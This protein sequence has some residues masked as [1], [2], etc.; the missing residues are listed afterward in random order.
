MLEEF[1]RIDV[2]VHSAGVGQEPG[3]RT[4]EVSVEAFDKVIDVNLRG[5]F[6][7]EREVLAAMVKQEERV[8]P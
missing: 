4:G 1:G 6:M 5:L 7:C 8:L 2:S 3:G